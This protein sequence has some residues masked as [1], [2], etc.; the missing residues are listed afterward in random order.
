MARQWKY[1]M[2]DVQQLHSFKTKQKTWGKK[3][4]I[5]VRT[6]FFLK[7]QNDVSSQKLQAR[8]IQEKS[9]IVWRDQANTRSQRKGKYLIWFKA[10]QRKYESRLLWDAGQSICTH[11]CQHSIKIH[12][13]QAVFITGLAFGFSA[14]FK[15]VGYLCGVM[16]AFCLIVADYLLFCVPNSF[17]ILS[18]L[19]E[20]PWVGKATVPFG[21]LFQ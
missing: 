16:L 7:L 21:Q 9:Q 19:P 17:D 1:T 18:W 20:V 14:F 12:T 5:C 8:Y 15:E 13:A 10:N 3:M 11:T 2:L 4:Y 6:C